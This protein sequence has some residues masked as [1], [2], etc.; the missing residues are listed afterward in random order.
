MK[1]TKKISVILLLLGMML[2]QLP[3]AEK[4]KEITS[5]LSFDLGYILMGLS[6]KGLAFGMNYERLF[7]D[8]FSFRVMAGAMIFETKEKDIYS[9]A[10]TTSVF[11]NY[12][13]FSD[14]LD[15]FYVGV[16]Q[17]IDYLNYFGS[18]TLP[19]PPADVLISF[20]PAVGWKQNVLNLVMLDFYANYSILVLNSQRL[21]N[22]ENYIRN[23]FRMGIKFKIFWRPWKDDD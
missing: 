13:P 14:T 10:F 23:G 1:N 15:K 18:A 12:Y 16:G 9:A 22:V 11:V 19:E 3:A 4:K 6:N 21:R 20:A 8:H 5:V 2:F 7:V 17:T